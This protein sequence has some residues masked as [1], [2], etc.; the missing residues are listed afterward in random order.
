VIAYRKLNQEDYAF[1]APEYRLQ[2]DD[3]LLLAGNEEDVARFTQERLPSA[4]K[5]LV[6]LFKKLLSRHP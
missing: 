2:A 5:G 6:G 1:Y 3:L 4:G